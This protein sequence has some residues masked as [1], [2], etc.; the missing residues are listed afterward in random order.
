MGGCLSAARPGRGQRAKPQQVVEQSSAGNSANAHAP[1]QQPKKDTPK[2]PPK[3]NKT[4]KKRTERKRSRITVSQ[5]KDNTSQASIPL[6]KR[7][8]FGYERDFKTK[9]KQGKLLGHGQ[10]GYTYSAVEISTGLKVAVKTI[11]KK[12]V[13]FVNFIWL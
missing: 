11:E 3:N 9:Y 4:P 6:G 13:Q 1:P 10:F 12:Q 7:T 8:N 5:I 2:K